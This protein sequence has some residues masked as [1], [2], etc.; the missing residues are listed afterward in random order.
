MSVT[1]MPHGLQIGLRGETDIV[2]RRSFA[3]PPER[4]WRALTDPAILPRWMQGYGG[5]MTHCEIDFRV[6]GSFDWRW[7]MADGTTFGFSGPYL[8]IEPYERIVHRELFN[9]DPASGCDV[10]TVLRPDGAG[11]RMEVTISYA[12]AAAREEA[13]ATGM[14]DGMDLTYANLDALLTAGSADA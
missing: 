14:T 6:G 10:T 9:G 3:A 1:D 8:A 13:L 5:H 2:V 12:S 4:V 11:T 7:V